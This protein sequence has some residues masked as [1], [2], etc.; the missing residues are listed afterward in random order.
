M[1]QRPET[2]YARSGDVMVAYQVTGEE[3]ALDLVHA[4]GSVSHLELFWDVPE[5][6]WLIERL[7]S[8]SRLILFD[9]RG[10]G[11]SD[12]PP[13][14]PT[15]EER[16]DDIRAVMDAAESERAF[17]FGS[18]EGAHMAAVFAATYPDRTAGLILWGAQARW[19]IAEDYPWGITEEE[20]LAEVERLAEF[21]IT[22]EWLFGSGAG[23]Y[24]GLPVEERNAIRRLFRSAS[25]PSAQAE[26]ERMR[27]TAISAASSRRSTCRP[28]S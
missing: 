11:M 24:P 27:C 6:A 26:L 8:F 2:R 15:L 25:T 1:I 5:A 12:R 3:H 14:A 4:I 28:S 20:G 7:S 16:T 13:G 19:T 9:K 21:G 23:A 10:T 18:S 22:D 17:I